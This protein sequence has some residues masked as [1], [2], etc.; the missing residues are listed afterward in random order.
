MCLAETDTSVVGGFPAGDHTVTT[1]D[2][3]VS[4][5]APEATSAR[6]EG[7]RAAAPEQ[8]PTVAG[9]ANCPGSPSHLDC[10]LMTGEELDTFVTLS[11]CSGASAE[12][13]TLAEIRTNFSARC[14]SGNAFGG[15]QG[16][17]PEVTITG[18]NT[19]EAVI[20]GVD[21]LV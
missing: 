4:K 14:G 13:A 16:A 5:A 10:S 7:E 18:T 3:E 11:T 2:Q 19:R 21:Q 6:P 1:P 8:G 12:R 9:N 17:A 20:R 15:P